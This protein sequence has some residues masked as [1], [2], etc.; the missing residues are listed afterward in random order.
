VTEGSKSPTATGTTTTTTPLGGGGVAAIKQEEVIQDQ[1]GGTPSK[2]I[3]LDASMGNAPPPPISTVMTT[4]AVRTVP[5]SQ[6]RGH[7]ETFHGVIVKIYT[8]PTT[9]KQMV[10]VRMDSM[11]IT[12]DSTHS[13]LIELDEV[14]DDDP[15]VL[16][17]PEE[18]VYHSDEPLNL[19]DHQFTIVRTAPIPPFSNRDPRIVHSRPLDLAVF[20]GERVGVARH[21]Q[22]GFAWSIV[23]D[24][25]RQAFSYYYANKALLAKE[26]TVLG[27]HL[28]HEANA[29]PAFHFK[30]STLDGHERVSSI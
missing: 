12:P 30:I 2:K 29:R 24:F 7:Y 9:K 17:F 15:L 5:K 10:V 28:I 25:D 11:H 22:L 3:K 4:T 6:T 16:E 20:P 21:S 14:P 19:L 26:G 27:P 13:Q 18:L 23:M 8:S 1:P